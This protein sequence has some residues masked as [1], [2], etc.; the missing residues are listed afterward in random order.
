MR[1]GGVC[2]RFHKGIG[3]F[4]RHYKPILD[5]WSLIDNSGGT[6]KDIA[7]EKQGELRIWNRDLYE[8]ILKLAEGR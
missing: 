8:K 6:P 2:R 7:E 5:S 4:F 3:N 1:S